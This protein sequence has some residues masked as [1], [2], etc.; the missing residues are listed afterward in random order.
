MEIS[1]ERLLTSYVMSLRDEVAAM[2]RLLAMTLSEATGAESKAENKYDTRSLES[3]YLAKGQGERLLALRRL[4]SWWESAPAGIDDRVSLGALVGA[5][6]GEERR[7]FLLSP[8]GGG[9]RIALD[10]R[11][12]AVITADSPAGRALLGARVGDEVTI[13]PTSLEVVCIA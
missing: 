2:E 8:D 4:L 6:A 10:Q 1:K 13:G 3:S 7:W 12:V 11:A 9:R 5:D